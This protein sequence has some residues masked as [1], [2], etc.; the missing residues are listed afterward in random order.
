MTP[1][2]PIRIVGEI[3]FEER[4]AEMAL[5]GRNL[6]NDLKKSGFPTVPPH[7]RRSA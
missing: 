6:N 7:I 5:P 1:N 3:L 2:A 4:S